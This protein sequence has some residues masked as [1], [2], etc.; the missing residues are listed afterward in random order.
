MRAVRR[1]PWP[2]FVENSRRELRGLGYL[3]G[4]WD[5]HRPDVRVMLLVDVTL[6]VVAINRQ[7]DDAHVTFILFIDVGILLLLSFF[8]LQILR[9]GLAQKSDRLTVRR[10]CGLLGAFGQGGEHHGLATTHGEQR[11]LCWLRFTVFLH[12]APEQLFLAV[13]RPAR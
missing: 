11:K 6:V 3:I 4:R 10:P 12:G 8:F 5:G 7:R 2:T 13:G 1:P 9:R